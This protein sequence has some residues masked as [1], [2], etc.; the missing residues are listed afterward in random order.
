MNGFNNEKLWTAF[1]ASGCVG[2]YLN[3]RVS[4]MTADEMDIISKNTKINT[5]DFFN[6]FE[7]DWRNIKTSQSW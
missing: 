1:E 4:K 7:S 2:D 5:R 6:G 3:Y